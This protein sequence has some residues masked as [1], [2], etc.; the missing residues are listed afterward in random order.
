MGELGYL[1]EEVGGNIVVK[2][3]FL[4]LSNPSNLIFVKFEVACA[5]LVHHE[6]LALYWK[7]LG[8]FANK[9]G[10]VLTVSFPCHLVAPCFFKLLIFVQRQRTRRLSCFL[11]YPLVHLNVS[12]ET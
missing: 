12:V 8:V 5:C 11:F 9:Q 1:P 2:F 7:S 10:L 6:L 4:E 3:K